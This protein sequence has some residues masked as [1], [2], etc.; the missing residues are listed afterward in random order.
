VVVALPAPEDVA[1]AAQQV[2]VSCVQ[3]S[4]V[5]AGD[6][7]DHELRQ[8][9]SPGGSPAGST[10]RAVASSLSQK[11]ATLVS[12]IAQLLSQN[13]EV[14]AAAEYTTLCIEHTLL[15][16]T[17]HESIMHEQTA[18]FT[19]LFSRAKTAKLPCHPELQDKISRLLCYRC[20]TLC[21]KRRLYIT[22]KNLSQAGCVCL[23][24]VKKKYSTLF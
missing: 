12:S 18:I 20:G 16:T 10:R 4:A 6:S 23:P 11:H 17:Y 14:A 21:A 8:P 3:P 9:A 24:F 15:S 2:H 7:A 1:G 22:N 13:H 19:Q 5:V